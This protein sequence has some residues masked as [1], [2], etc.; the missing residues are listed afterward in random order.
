MSGTAETDSA[1]GPAPR[2]GRVTDEDLL[3]THLA[4][5]LVLLREERAS[6]V[7]EVSEETLHSSIYL[8]EGVPVFAEGGSVDDSLGRVLL[9]NGSLSREGYV[10]IL[11]RMTDALVDDELMRFGEVAIELGLLSPAQ[12][13]TALAE[14][15]RCKIQRCLHASHATWVFREDHAAVDLVAR[16]PLRIEQ[17]IL[18]ALLDPDEAERWAERLAPKEEF[19]VVLGSGD[20]VMTTAVGLTPTR[21]RLMRFCD[22]TRTLGEVLAANIVSRREAVA[23]LTALLLGGRATLSQAPQPRRREP[24]GDARPPAPRPAPG[25]E[26]AAGPVAQPDPN[27]AER[28]AR[29]AQVRAELERRGRGAPAPS[30]ARV[31]LTAEQSFERGRRLYRDG[32]LVPAQKEL[33]RA[34]HDMPGSIEASLWASF[35]DYLLADAERQRELAPELERTSLSALR[36]DKNFAFAHHVQ[37]RLRHAS[38]DEDGARKA[39]RIAVQLDPDDD[40]SMRFARLLTARAKR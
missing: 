14:Q 4:R 7:L 17:V 30:H 22:G 5:V 26:P 38:G 33:A 10:R 1:E 27:A 15:V 16:F 11:Q 34:R 19:F 25:P 39:F 35:V 20:G 8:S 2:A 37:G 28:A 13:S 29:A 9:K 12:V 6:G 32:K 3:A 21:L 36:H 31:G 40:E 24:R 18:D 23:L